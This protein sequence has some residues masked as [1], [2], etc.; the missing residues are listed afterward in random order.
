MQEEKHIRYFSISW[1]SVHDGNGIRTVVYL[2]GCNLRCPW[3]HSPHSQE[4]TPGLLFFED[5]CALCRKCG[6]VCKY[7]VHSFTGDK[8]I[9]DL[10]KCVKCGECVKS[11]PTV[12]SSQSISGA[13]ALSFNIKT[14]ENL[15]NMLYPQLDLLRDI[16]GLTVSG[17]EP[18]LQI[19]ALSELLFMCKEKNINTAVETSGSI[20][21][22]KFKTLLGLVDTWLF[23][24][25]P[26]N[27]NIAQRYN[28]G[29]DRIIEENLRLLKADNQDVIIRT[30]LIPGFTTSKEHL[31]QIADI[32]HKYNM[33]YIELLPFNKYT[34]HFYTASGKN[35]ELTDTET[36]EP[37][38][39]ETE[40]F[41]IQQKI[42][43][44]I[45]SN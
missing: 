40:S 42:R 12:V 29:D 44:K 35:F 20:P 1:N 31:Q 5:R 21:Y 34:R 13:I 23:G 27:K 26:V 36:A 4:Q 39:A 9:L 11:C 8:H 41:F 28:L 30:P 37:E 3:C 10:A 15:F 19:S 2:Q 32:M 6:L 25:R 14:P 24:L 17:G 22:S 18:L 16:G 7:D 33:D 38:I 43:T 45:I